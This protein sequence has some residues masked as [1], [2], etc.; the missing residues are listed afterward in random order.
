MKILLVLPAVDRYRVR[1]G[2][3]VS[4]RKMLR[5]SILPL[6]TIAALT[7]PEHEVR[8]CDENV[9]ALDLNAE[10]DLVGI[11]FMTALAPRAYE[12]AAAFRKRG[13]PV[14]AG[15]YHPTFCPQEVALH[16]D[17]AVIG[18]AE[19]AWAPLLADA[20]RGQL[21][22]FYRGGPADPAHIPIPRRDL[23]G[24]NA[25]YY[26]TTN[27]VQTGR[28]C[29][30]TCRYCSI[31][32]FFE[33]A[34]RQRP[35]SSVLKELDEVP[36]YFMFVDDNIISDRSYACS[37]FAAM[38]PL[39]KR[40]VS[41]CDLKIADD[42]ELLDLAY[43]AGC[44]GLFIGIETANAKNLAS[45]DKAFNDA[46]RYRE[47]ISRIRRRGIAVQAGIIV[48]LDHDDV[49]VFERTLTWLDALGIDAI[50]LNILTP[51]P[52]TP[53]HKDFEKNGRIVDVDLAHYDFR[54]AVIRPAMMSRQELQEG[55]DWLYAQYYR[56]DRVFVRA[57]KTLR[58]VGI[59]A[60]LTA[61]RLNLTYRYD[62]RR[63]GIV[64]RNPAEKTR[65]PA[66][67]ALCSPC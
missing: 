22:K 50:Q 66:K 29:P 9:E 49:G 10:V 6:T 56:L 33:H 44:R 61:L 18:E 30:H 40:W 45:V 13:I 19:N 47:R 39:K 38:L 3:K 32:A 15:G 23:I 36:R 27:A 41:Q 16:F 63:E 17:A 67:S 11:S 4:R 31:T 62:N 1:A 37:L 7:P 55:A 59:L 64:G 46:Q 48:G 42:P 2:D 43:H 54:H 35:V 65:M 57:A 58:D 60:A 24:P 14:V 28:G 5:F 21:Q 8:L 52:G 53:L 12:I 25:R 34:H 51:L 20:Q 26:I